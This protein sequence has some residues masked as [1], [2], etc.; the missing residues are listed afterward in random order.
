MIEEVEGFES[1]GVCGDE[2]V[3]E[4]EE[5]RVNEEVKVDG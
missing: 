5:G 1:E 3:G 2:I 4:S